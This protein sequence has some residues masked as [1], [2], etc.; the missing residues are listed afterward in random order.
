[1]NLQQL[2][3]I[4]AIV[5]H[6]HNISAA[7]EALERSQSGLSRQVKELE[8]ELGAQI[9]V[10]TR[11]KVIGLTPQGERILHIAQRVLQDLRALE[12]IGGEQSAEEG[13]EL[14][15]ATTHVHARYLLPG[16]VKAFTRRFPRV[17]VTLQQ[18]EPVQCRSLIAT[19]EA[20]MGI[21]TMVQKPADPVVA[22]P[23]YQLPRCVVVP[24]GHPLVR[25]QRPTLRKLA[26]YPLIAYP[27]TFSGRTIVER[28]FT[29]AGLKPH[30]VCS[31]TDADVC[32]AYVEVG[33]GIA[34]LATIAFDPAIDRGLVAID[35]GH[36][37]RPGILSIV[38]RKHGYLTR[39]LESFLAQFAPHISRELI[40]KAMDGADIDRVQLSARAPVAI[41][42]R[43]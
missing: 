13:G 42:S 10:R 37:F 1:M 23:A 34:V 35:A 7:A 19:G 29:R 32:K 31:A 43:V 20:D 28:A 33:M 41:A 9:F 39:P 18:T 5:R 24:E 12:Q 11:N 2:Q 16:A 8:I 3:A 38:L 21:I 17:A 30:I 15:I 26:E 4:C 27:A 6:R 25:E 36:L 40:V 14:R 22:I